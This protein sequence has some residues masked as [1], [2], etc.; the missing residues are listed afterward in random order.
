M[1]AIQTDGLTKR[2]GHDVYAVS[3]L[4]L[5]VEEGEVFGFLGPNGAGKSTTIDLLMDFVRPSS[6]SATVLGYDVQEEAGAVHERVGILPDG[7]SLYHRLSGRK[8]VEYAIALKESDDD[9]DDILERVGLDPDAA[10]RP[11][12]TYSKG[13]SQRLALGMALVGDPDVLILDEPSSGLDPDGIRDIRELA[14]SH[15][16]DGGTVFFSSHILSQV[17]AVCDRVGILSNGR[18]VAIDTIDG[19]RDAVGTGA[20]IALVV[21]AAPS[22]VDLTDIPGVADVTVTDGVV[23]ATCTEP[24]SKVEFVDRVRDGGSTV[25]DIET[26]EASLEDLFSAYTRPADGR[27]V[28]EVDQ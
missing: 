11:A 13:M 17:E 16:D 12:R 1:P 7:Y 28:V 21:D 24:S 18:L 27:L 20:T 9:P 10:A 25:L 19:L 26:H 15:A 8:H 6:G 22:G 4:S 14:R 5:T 2:Y 23:S 3:D